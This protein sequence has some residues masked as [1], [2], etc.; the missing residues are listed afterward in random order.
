[1]KRL[2]NQWSKT[3]AE[4]LLNFHVEVPKC[5]A[6]RVPARLMR[7]AKHFEQ[8]V[9]TPQ[10]SIGQH[11]QELRDGFNALISAWALPGRHWLS[12]GT[13]I[14]FG[15]RSSCKTNKSKNLPINDRNSESDEPDDDD[16]DDERSENEDNVSNDDYGGGVHSRTTV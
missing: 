15:T 9:T 5:Q 8:K 7:N 12:K 16:G 11:S 10:Q 6:C 4:V 3:I 13:N 14:L 2:F 1:M